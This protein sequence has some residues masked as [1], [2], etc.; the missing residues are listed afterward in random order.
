KM[1]QARKALKLCLDNLRPQDRFGII[2]FATTVNRY[3]DGLTEAS[4]EY[5]D[6]AK[7]WCDKLKATGGTAINEALMQA[8]AMRG[9]DTGRSFNI[10][11]FTDGQPTIGESDTNKIIKNVMAK[12][13]ANTRIFT[14]GVGEADGIDAAFLDRLA[15]DTRAVSTF[16]KPAEDIE[17][18]T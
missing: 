4:S 14:F 15:E 11:F 18:K 13:T 1:E 10:I 2:Q 5:V 17:T 12:N 6:N 8:L 3:R 9:D 16:V 7:K